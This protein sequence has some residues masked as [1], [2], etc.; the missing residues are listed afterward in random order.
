MVLAQIWAQ[1]QWI[2]STSLPEPFQGP[3]SRLTGWLVEVTQTDMD[4]DS[5]YR[6]KH[7]MTMTVVLHLNAIVW[8]R[9]D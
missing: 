7:L 5:A 9:R 8:W 1:V 2:C 6:L 4:I 3:R